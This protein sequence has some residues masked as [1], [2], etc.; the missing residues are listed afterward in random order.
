MRKHR[1]TFPLIELLVVIGIIALLIGILVPVLGRARKQANTVVCLAHLNQI[2]KAAV[3]YAVDTRGYTIPASYRTF[4]H[5]GNDSDYRE[6]WATLLINGKYIPLPTPAPTAV[7]GPL[8]AGMQISG[9]ITAANS[10][11]YCPAG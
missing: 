10:I 6:F 5:T 9:P 3:M 11:F 4:G 8:T 2:G 1:S 7:T